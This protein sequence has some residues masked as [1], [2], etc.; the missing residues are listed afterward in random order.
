MCVEIILDLLGIFIDVDF[1]AGFKKILV[2]LEGRT[3]QLHLHPNFSLYLLFSIL[4]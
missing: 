2:S 1:I 3:A 4:M